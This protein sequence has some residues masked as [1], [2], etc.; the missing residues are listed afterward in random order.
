LGCKTFTGATI[1]QPSSI[2]VLPS[3]GLP[4]CNGVCNG[5]ITLN[6]SGGV[7]AYSYSWTPAAPNTSVLTGLCAGNY[8]VNIGHNAGNCAQSMTFNVPGQINLTFTDNIVQNTCFG[9][10]NGAIS[11]S[12]IPTIGIPSPFAFSWNTGQ[13]SPGPFSTSLT[14]LCNGIYS[15]IA[16]GANGCFSTYSVNISSPSQL[17][18]TA[19]VTQPSCNLANGA[20]TVTP[21]GGSG[22]TYSLNW[23]NGATTSTLNNLIAGFYNLT[24]TDNLGCT[25]TTL[26]SID[27][28]SGITNYTVTTLDIPCGATC[29]G[30]ATIVANG[31][32]TPISYNWVSPAVNSQ[33]LNNLCA[34][35]YFI[36][37]QDNQGC[38]KNGSMTINAATS[39]TLSPFVNLPACGFTNGTINLVVGW[40]TNL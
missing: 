15:V 25:Q 35:T 12:V 17:S 13:T 39:I 18:I 26:V 28:S 37:M 33:T 31:T 24:I 10:C 5:S 16:T 4:T 22:P 29:T 21:G 19:A 8:T 20:V 3:M 9:N 7:P 23:S 30:A 32:N 34:G 38:I 14:S 1:T 2:S 36:Q 40:N 27:N 11:L 6:L